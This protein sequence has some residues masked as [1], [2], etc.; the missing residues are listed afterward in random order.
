MKAR[1][2]KD[3]ECVNQLYLDSE[4]PI[5]EGIVPIL[6][7]PAGTV[8]DNP[9]AWMMCANGTATPEDDE[10]R[11]KTLEFMGSAKRKTFIQQI[12]ALR[13]ANGAQQLDQKTKKWLE[14]AEKA[15]AAELAEPASGPVV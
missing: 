5:A 1:L 12:K 11:D 4:N 6:V 14:Y 7:I 10:C 9:D 13:N 2:L 8:I 15:Y 3:G